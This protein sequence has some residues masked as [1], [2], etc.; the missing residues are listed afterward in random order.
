MDYNLS[1]EENAKI[2]MEQ[3]A[4]Q[5]PVTL[6]QARA[7][8]FHV[9]AQTMTLYRLFEEEIEKLVQEQDNLG[10][11]SIRFKNMISDCAWQ[12]IKK[13]ISVKRP[14]SGFISYPDNATRIESLVISDKYKPLFT[15]DEINF[16][17]E[18]LGQ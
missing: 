4:K 8:D 9:R 17:R 5:K 1:F 6:E 16:C 15:D 18:Q 3:L 13:L 12:A 7:Q 11:V 10:N 2:A 14:T